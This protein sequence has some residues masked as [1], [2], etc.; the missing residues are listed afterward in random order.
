[1]AQPEKR[2]LIY[3]QHLL[4][5]G[6]I[7]RAMALARAMIEDGLEVCLVTGGMPT[8][9]LKLVGGRIVQLPPIRALDHK[10]TKLVDDQD[11]QVGPELERQRRDMLLAVLDDFRPHAIITELYPLGRRKMTFELEPLIEAARALSPRPLIISSVRDILVRSPKSGRAEEAIGRV[12]KWYD[13]VLVHSVESIISLEGSYPE[14]TAIRDKMTYTGFVAAAADISSSAASAANEILVSAGSGVGGDQ[15]YDIALSLTESDINVAGDGVVWRV[16]VGWHVAEDKYLALKARGDVLGPRV[17]VERARPDFSGLLYSCLLSVSQCGY[18][19]AMEVLRAN[20]RAVMVPFD[21]F[22]ETEQMLRAQLLVKAG[23]IEMVK[24]ADLTTG[25][26]T[27][28]IHRALERD[29][30]DFVIDLKG[31]ENSASLVSG[32]IDNWTGD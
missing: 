25:T 24:T 10:F 12:K 22:V 13:H 18:N 32:W 17:V 20:A 16:L 2:V 23:R 31:D 7:R 11:R 28:A 30:V 21:A 5:I 3:V 8:P 15:L 4:G 19:T 1:M 26:L 9:D 6:H 27:T 14:V 29:H